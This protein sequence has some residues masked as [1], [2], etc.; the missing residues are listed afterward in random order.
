MHNDNWR[1]RHP[2]LLPR[3]A[4]DIKRLDVKRAAQFLTSAPIEEVLAVRGLDK[5]AGLR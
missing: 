1:E 3:S 2:H 5:L 4:N